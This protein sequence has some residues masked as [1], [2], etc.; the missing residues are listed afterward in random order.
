MRCPRDTR[1]LIV[2]IRGQGTRTCNGR[3]RVG[4]V[5]IY[6]WEWRLVVSTARFEQFGLT[7]RWTL[8]SLA[9]LYCS[10]NGDQQELGRHG[11]GG[12]ERYQR[13]ARNVAFSQHVCYPS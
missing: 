6:Y 8:I 4:E 1:L 13:S 2:R 7:G 11:Q 9:H 10:G 5:L 12:A 3:K